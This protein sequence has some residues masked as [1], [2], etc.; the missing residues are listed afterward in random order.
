M[1]GGVVIGARG[2]AVGVRPWLAVASVAL[3]TFVVV[4][5]EFLP[6]GLLGTIAADLHVSVGT[7]GLMVAIPGVVAALAAPA[8][9]VL[10][11]TIDRRL[12]LIGCAA[13]VM[14]SNVIVALAPGFATILVARVLLG[15]S[16]GGFWTFAVAAGRRLVPEVHGGRAT[17][18][19]LAGIS[20][21]TV[22][23]VPIGTALGALA[24]WRFAFGSVAALAGLTVLGQV[25]LLSSLPSRHVV[26]FGSLLGVFTVPATTTG[27][28]ATALVAAGHF[29][30]YTYLEPFLSRIVHL[31]PSGISG[32]LAAY[33]AAGVVGNFAGERATASDLRRSFIGIALLLGLAVL[34]AAA[35]GAHATGA[36]LAV[37]LWGAAFGAVP[38][39]AQI[40]TYRSAPERFET[41]SAMMVTVFQIALAAGSLGGGAVVDRA[42]IV[43]AFILGGVLSLGCGLLVLRARPPRAS[44]AG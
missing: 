17:A 18:L 26:S 4:T 10:A 7:A 20:I 27:F 6:I 36:V 24:G 14:L 19:I 16:V 15:I 3:G 2:D 42:G 29:T 33:G 30:A 28:L 39:C 40:W 32:T 13:L 12:L 23:G 11:K 25:L 44:D 31:T 8:I 21:G 35:S 41:G 38:V 37:V 22:V 9:T 43:P 5:T 34:M 1:T